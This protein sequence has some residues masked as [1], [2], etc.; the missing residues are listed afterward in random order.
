MTK[1]YWDIKHKLTQADHAKLSIWRHKHR[2]SLKYYPNVVGLIRK[3]NQSEIV[4]LNQHTTDCYSVDHTIAPHNISFKVRADA[5]LF[6]LT[7]HGTL[8][9]D[10]HRL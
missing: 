3:P 10:V 6:K 7:W 9:C 4:W 2:Q 8:A 1:K 5:M